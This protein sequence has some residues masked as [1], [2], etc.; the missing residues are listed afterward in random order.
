[1]NNARD[2]FRTLS[3]IYYGAFLAKI[4]DTEAAIQRCS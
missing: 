2:A 3:N 4:V 1:M